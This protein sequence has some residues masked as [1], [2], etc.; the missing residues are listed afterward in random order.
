LAILRGRSLLKVLPITWITR[1]AA[2]AMLGLAI[3]SGVAA[4]T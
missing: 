3:Y 1:A 2:L 4:A